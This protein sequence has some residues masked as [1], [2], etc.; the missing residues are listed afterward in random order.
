MLKFLFFYR[1][2]HSIQGIFFYVTS[3]IQF[4]SSKIVWK[5]FDDNLSPG[6]LQANINIYCWGHQS[7]TII[8]GRLGA[9]K[10]DESG[11][12]FSTAASFSSESD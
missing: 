8:E 2:I 10:L 7:A 5:T 4:H 3:L 9:G 1:P 6:W 12:E 11:K